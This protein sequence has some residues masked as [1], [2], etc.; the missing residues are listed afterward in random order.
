VLY[1]IRMLYNMREVTSGASRKAMVLR[2]FAARAPRRT[3]E[4]DG[5][6]S[7]DFVLYAVYRGGIDCVELNPPAADRLGGWYR[8]A[9]HEV[10]APS[11]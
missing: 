4:N 2:L 9:A 3:A 5:L 7:M 6:L 1:S 11:G 10:I 8:R